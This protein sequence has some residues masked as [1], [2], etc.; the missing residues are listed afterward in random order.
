[1]TLVAADQPLDAA[2]TSLLDPLELTFRVVDEKTLQVIAKKPVGARYELEI[3]PVANLLDR[4]LEPQKILSLIRE[5]IDPKSWVESG[6]VGVIALDLLEIADRAAK[7]GGSNA[8]GKN[9]RQISC[10]T[11]ERKTP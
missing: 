2:P 3:H 11:I 1:M 5:K 7:P 9:A 10:G 8:A 4:D 6:G